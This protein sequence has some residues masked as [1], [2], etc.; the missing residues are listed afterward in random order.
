[1]KNSNQA[2]ILLPDSPLPSGTEY[3]IGHDGK[4]SKWSSCKV[5]FFA[6][7]ISGLLGTA[8]F[9]LSQSLMNEEYN[10]WNMTFEEWKLEHGKVY[11]QE[12][13]EEMKVIWNENMELIRKHNKEAAAGKH[14]YTLKPSHKTDLSSKE[15]SKTKMTSSSRST[16]QQCEAYS[17]EPQTTRKEVDWRSKAV[18]AVQDQGKCGSCWAF[19]TIGTIEGAYARK[20]DWNMSLIGDNGFSE[21]QLVDCETREAGYE[22]KGCSGGFSDSALSYTLE[23]GVQTESSYPYVGDTRYYDYYYSSYQTKCDNTEGRIKPDGCYYIKRKSL[24]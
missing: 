5:I 9:I 17:F 10:E 1:M 13:E 21:Q 24:L 2:R 14:S 19:A 16:F 4:K 8:I 7:F 12:L 15:F 20:M 23:N 6:I 22:A 18:S 3:T 11:T